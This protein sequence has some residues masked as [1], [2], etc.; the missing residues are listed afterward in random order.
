MIGVPAVIQQGKNELSFNG[1]TMVMKV[2]DYVDFFRA[3]GK[4]LSETPMLTIQGEAD[5]KGGTIVMEFEQGNGKMVAPI[6]LC[7][8]K[9]ASLMFIS[10]SSFFSLLLMLSRLGRCSTWRI[11][12]SKIA[13]WFVPTS[14]KLHG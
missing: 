8:V 14:L 3:S 12:L 5:A 4:D 11:I 1:E 6:S 10:S 13:S 7:C 2:S 9:F